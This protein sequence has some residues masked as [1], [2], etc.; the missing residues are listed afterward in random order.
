MSLGDEIKRIY[1]QGTTLTKLILINLA[2]F[3]AIKIISVIFYLIQN[4]QG[5]A[6]VM[7]FLALPADLS[8]LIK[9]PWTIL[10]YM[11][12]HY[13]FFHILFNMLWLYWFGR[14]F[15]EY[16]DQK[17]LLS[18]YLLGGLAG[19]ALY[20]ISYNISPAFRDALPVSVAL[21]A[22][23]AV[24][25]IVMAISFYVPDYRIMLMFIGPVKLKYLAI[26]VILID[27]LSIQGSNAGGHI[28][29][30]GGALFGILYAG[31]I[32]RG[33]DLS[34]GFNRF[35]DSL[36]SLF[37]P[38]PKMKVKYKKP[39]G[40]VE[41]D[42]EYNARKA[43]E[44]KEIDRILEKISKSGYDALTKEEKEILFRSSKK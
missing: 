13:G 42:I 25:A 14:I 43:E 37:K 5:D 21:G 15:L 27:V 31:Q 7:N 19:G 30:L 18:I 41:T 6:A 39:E 32:K 26:A 29:H 22:S 2:V 38:R 28:A 3:L 11:F 12:L 1:N 8:V 44:Q 33:K 4:T 36:I 16:L 17:K 34:R 20:I 23:A 40:K 24:M 9:R 10:T 35:M